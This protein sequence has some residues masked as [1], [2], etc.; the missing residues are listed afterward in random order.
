MAA[1]LVE[2]SQKNLISFYC[3]WHQHGRHIIVFLNPKG[4]IASHQY[5][6]NSISVKKEILKEIGSSLKT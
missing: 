2:L 1:M 4:L 6:R 5:P 3:M